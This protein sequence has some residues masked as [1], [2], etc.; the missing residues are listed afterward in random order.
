MTERSIKHK[1]ITCTGCI[2]LDHV[3][4]I[5]C[6]DQPPVSS[7]RPHKGPYDLPGRIFSTW[8]SILTCFQGRYH[9]PYDS[10]VLSALSP[11]LVLTLSSKKQ[12]LVNATLTFWTATFDRVDHLMYPNKLRD[13]FMQYKKK[14]QLDLRLPGFEVIVATCTCTWMYGVF[15]WVGGLVVFV[16]FWLCTDFHVQYTVVHVLQTGHTCTCTCM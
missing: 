15:F 16:F 12:D 1:P 6:R 7:Q 4:Y 13:I 5:L 2:R 8:K 11:L 14:A 3:L 10:A 9:S